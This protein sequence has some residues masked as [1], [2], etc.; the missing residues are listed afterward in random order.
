MGS[1]VSERAVGR[2]PAT[3]STWGLERGVT[4]NA[5]SVGGVLRIYHGTAGSPTQYEFDN[6]KVYTVPH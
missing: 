4:L 2:V 6:V 5:E 3:A 1:I